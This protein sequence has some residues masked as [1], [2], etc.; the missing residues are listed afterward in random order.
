[1]PKGFHTQCLCVLLKKPIRLSH[2]LDCLGNYEI[3]D[4]TETGYKWAITGPACAIPFRPE[5]N[6]IATVDIVDRVWP[7]DLGHPE[8][9]PEIFFPWSFG[10][11]GPAAFPECLIRAAL[12]SREWCQA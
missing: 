12:S 4:K 5:V 7:D 3:S 6:G 8:T 1:M 9:A 2:L 11:F 10:S